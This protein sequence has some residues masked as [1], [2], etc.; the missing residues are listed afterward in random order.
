MK[1]IGLLGF[2]SFGQFMVKHLVQ[3]FEVVVWN[4]SPRPDEAKNLGV[5]QVS[6]AEAC[7][8]E[9]VI[10]CVPVQFLEKFTY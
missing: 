4:R 9:I 6:I 2:G 8:A 3:H 10:P 5:K 7:D 1:K